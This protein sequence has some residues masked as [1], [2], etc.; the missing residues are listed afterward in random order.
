MVDE[1]VEIR[2]IVFLSFH[3]ARRQSCEVSR[4]VPGPLGKPCGVVIGRNGDGKLARCRGNAPSVR[5]VSVRVG[6]CDGDN[7][8]AFRD[9]VILNGESEATRSRFA[10]D[11]EVSDGVVV[12]GCRIVTVFG[13]EDV[14]VPDGA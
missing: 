2:Q 5:E 12:C 11:N 10:V 7:F 9:V 6:K 1:N 8:P 3:D 13:G 4:I 14:R